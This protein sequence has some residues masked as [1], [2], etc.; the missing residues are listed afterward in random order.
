MALSEKA[1]AGLELPCIRCGD[2][3]P[4]CPVGLDPQQL[5]VRLRA[6]HDD[7]ATSLGL[8]DCTACAACDAACP[9]HI[10]LAHQFR[11]GREALAA[12]TTLLQ[13]AMAARE[14]FEQRGQRLARELE[15]R[16][17]RDLELARQAS[18]GDAVAA[19][20]ERAK[21]RRRPDN[22]E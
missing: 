7:V 16:K 8:E 4:A 6:G 21:A 19:A 22:P 15:V 5:H 2:C 10:P 9:S 3:L 14:R 13:Q 11:I 1:D 20:L 12:R 18:S 17:Q